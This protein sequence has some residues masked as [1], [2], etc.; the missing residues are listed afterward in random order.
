[1]WRTYIDLH[2]DVL[3]EP[4]NVNTN[5]WPMYFF[6]RATNSSSMVGQVSMCKW[7]VETETSF[8]KATFFCRPDA[9]CK[10]QVNGYI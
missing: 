9:I 5:E 10:K 1:M 3:L 8:S 2:R 7:L 4:K 6:M